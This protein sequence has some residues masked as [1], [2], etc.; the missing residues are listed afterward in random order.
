MIHPVYS[1][2]W[3][4]DSKNWK[5]KKTDGT[6]GLNCC[7]SNMLYLYLLYFANVEANAC[8]HYPSNIF[9]NTRGFEN[10]DLAR[11]IFSHVTRLDNR[12]RAKIVRRIITSEIQVTN[13]LSKLGW[14]NDW[15]SVDMSDD[16][17]SRLAVEC[18]LCIGCQVVCPWWLTIIPLAVVG[19]EMVRQ[20]W[21]I[22]TLE[23]HY[24]M[25]QF[26]KKI[27]DSWCLV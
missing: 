27:T 8:I 12:P 21:P 16:F 19:Y 25:I 23:L 10:W 11:K 4:R 17:R 7:I 2:R 15:V 1:V 22:K 14:Q 6:V 26:F 20:S 18:P 9:R 3:Y 5:T 24:S 13:H